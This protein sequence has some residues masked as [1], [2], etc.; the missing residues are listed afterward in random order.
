MRFVTPDEPFT[1]PRLFLVSRQEAIA[2]IGGSL[3]F[4]LV[5][6]YPAFLDFKYLG[7]GFHG[8]LDSWPTLSHLSAVWSD[9]DRDVFAELRWVPYYTITH[10]HQLPFWNPYKCGGMPMLGN[11]ESG[12]VSPFLLLYLAF[13]LMPGIILEIYFHIAIAF[14]GGYLL[15]RELGL[16]PLASIVLA[17]MFPS[18]SWLSLHVAQGHLNFLSSA[19]LPLIM[20]LMLTACRMRRWY[21]AALGG[22]VCALTL[23]EGNYAFAFAA[24]VVAVVGVTLSVIRLS[25]RPL[26]VGTLIGIF[27]LAFGALKLI[28][29]AELLTLYP[30]SGLGNWQSWSGVFIALFSRNQNLY[31]E[32]FPR[33]APFFFSEYGGYVGA[34]FVVLALIGIVAAGRDAIAWVLAATLFFFM[35]RGDTA[36]YMPSVLLRHL[37]LAGNTWLCGR[38]VI[39][40]VFCFAVLAALGAECLCKRGGAWGPRLAAILLTVGLVDAWMVCSPNYRYLS[41]PPSKGPFPISK[42]FRQYWVAANALAMTPLAEANMGAPNCHCCGYN[43]P[44]GSVLGYNEPGYRGEYYLLGAGEVKQTE[45]TPNRLSYD[46]NVPAATSLVINQNMYPGWHLMRGRGSVYAENKLIA[47]RI[48][49]GHQQI[50]LVF[51][52][53]HILAAFALTLLASA[54]LFLLWWIETRGQSA[55]GHT[56]VDSAAANETA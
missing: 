32:F 14:F 54:A 45:W 44:Q 13:G 16:R 17:A 15:G 48:P 49:A 24:L 9:T 18:S 4:A 5:F 1:R 10:F 28:P 52:P 38:W 19:Y 11:P 22:L 39:P 42:S 12:I 3:A 33:F 47:V 23:T 55:R 21:P 34:P 29:A 25:I 31:R 8:W 20:A 6:F 41:Q 26:I 43:L 35:F 40:L 50:E 46:V 37:P 30:R 7:P 36:P 56:N 53:S 27:A 2:L 51:T